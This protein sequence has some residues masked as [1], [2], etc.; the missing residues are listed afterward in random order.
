MIQT[1]KKYHLSPIS[2]NKLEKDIREHFVL[3]PFKSL[4]KN[5]CQKLG[6]PSFNMYS[7]P[8]SLATY[9]RILMLLL[10]ITV[11][12]ASLSAKD[13]LKFSVADFDTDPFD[14]S[15]KDKQYEKYDGNGERY[16]IIKVTSNNPEDDLSEYNFNFGNLKHIVEEHN[17]VLWLY[18][19]RNA[20]LV[21]ITR[22][23]Y[24][25]IN[26]YDLRT[27]IES[28]KNYVMMLTSE[29][30][31]VYTQMVQFNIK[32]ANSKAIVMVK[33]F[34][35]DSQE[36][37]FGNIDATG[38]VA[39]SLEYGTYTYKVLA[40]N[41]HMAEGRFTL[42]NRSETLVENVELRP[43]FSD[44]TFNV[45]ADADIY[46]N[47][48]R[49]G[50]RQWS[51]VLKAGNYQVECRQ[52]N[53]KST[54]QYIQVTENDNQ[55]INLKAPEPILG[56]AAITST[57]LGAEII[58][59][60]KTYGQT[61]KNLDL[62][63]GK[64]KIEICKKGYQSESQIFEVREDRTVDVNMT[65][66]RMTSAT[67]KSNPTSSKLYIDG[68]YKGS[69]PYTYEGEVG[70][71]KI[72]L[73]YCGYKSIE[74]KVYFGNTDQ[75]TFSLQKQYVKNKDIY[76][77]A[78]IGV[79]SAMN[80]CAAIGGHIAN[81]NI[82]VDYSYC[83][84]KSP[85]IYWN[86]IGEDY[87]YT[88]DACTYSP[89]LILAGKIGYGIIVGTRFKITPQIGY[90]F[91]KLSES[92]NRLHNGWYICGANCSAATIGVRAYC[93]ISSHFGISLTPEYAIGIAKSDGFKTLSE[94]T[95]KI[96]NMGE[97]F[98]AKFALVL[99]F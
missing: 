43:N 7:Q 75:M 31:K 4:F 51:G 92:G 48:E 59:D 94:V 37:L 10:F 12:I 82:E 78:G 50:T 23:G 93:A 17:G 8:T 81:F 18:V 98:N 13:K 87:D 35:N 30:K 22:N 36:E 54:S 77:E 55:T 39:K 72:K 66:G 6:K 49:K 67:I 53:H 26:K 79:G 58:V 61:P 33:S 97:G 16:A 44:M 28:G 46:I 70:D 41:Y 52:I 99:T 68:A 9:S 42:N 73:M 34:K 14:L 21:T 91:T 56:T 95:T 88:P 71:H 86:Y 2:F 76:I 11:G 45:D 90:R 63:I 32:P 25:P 20:K 57:P 19:Q 5:S 85:T 29:E 47:G 89:S 1:N 83:F 27:T 65:L 74:K 80:V 15:A 96:K 38:A 62:L 24:I 60:G 40:D 84:Q 3:K 69:T 64:H